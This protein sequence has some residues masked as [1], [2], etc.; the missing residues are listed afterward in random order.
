[1]EMKYQMNS[2]QDRKEVEEIKKDPATISK[3]LNG[4]FEGFIKKNQLIK[5]YDFGNDFKVKMRPCKTA[6]LM[7]A[8]LFVRGQNPGV[9]IDTMVK[10]RAAAILSKAIVSLCG[11]EIEK[12]ELDEKDNDIRRISLYTKLL[13]L[14]PELIEKM[15]QSYIDVVDEQAGMFSNPG[16]LKENIENF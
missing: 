13:D 3:D 10:L 4:F 11:V 2:E 5:E 9:P 16:Q 15:Y 12:P 7:D 14:P 6:E 8:E 1:M